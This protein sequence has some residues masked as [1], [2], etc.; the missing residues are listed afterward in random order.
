MDCIAP[1]FFLAAPL[2]LPDLFELEKRESLTQLPVRSEALSI[3]ALHATPRGPESIQ[4]LSQ[5]LRT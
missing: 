2:S 5:K 1:I 3:L 4:T